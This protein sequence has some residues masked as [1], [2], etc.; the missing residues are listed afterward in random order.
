MW[1]HGVFW[2]SY[3]KE[4]LFC[5]GDFFFFFTLWEGSGLYDTFVRVD[6][7]GCT[8]L[9]LLREKLSYFVGSMC[10]LYAPGLALLCLQPENIAS[11]ITCQV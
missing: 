4:L 1:E 10:V 5:F 11:D 9:R 3:G 8:I 2:I 6:L 7:N